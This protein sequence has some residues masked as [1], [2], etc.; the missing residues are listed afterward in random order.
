MNRWATVVN[1]RYWIGGWIGGVVILDTLDALGLHWLVWPV[2]AALTV[3]VLV[4]SLIVLR[5]GRRQ[6]R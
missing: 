1:L 4:G 6:G 2:V 3:F 5:R